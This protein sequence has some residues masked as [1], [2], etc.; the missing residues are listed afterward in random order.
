[1]EPGA[2]DAVGFRGIVENRE[3]S[4]FSS[5]SMSGFLRQP[6]LHSLFGLKYLIKQKIRGLEVPIHK[7]CSPHTLQHRT[8]AIYAD[9]LPR[10]KRCFFAR[11]IRNH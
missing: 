10:H 9:Y 4:W 5:V 2:L 3:R 1:V 11:E 6:D 7:M 8:P